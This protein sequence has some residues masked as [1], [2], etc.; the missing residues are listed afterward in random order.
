MAK[1]LQLV[2]D[3]VANR[4][5]VESGVLS[6]GRHPDNNVQIED[7][8]VSGHH[9][10]IRV[11]PNPDFPDY[12]EYFLEDLG[13]TNGSFVNDAKV[14]AAVQLHHGDIIRIAY[15]L[16]RFDLEASPS[17]AKTMHILK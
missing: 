1:L 11:C 13:S 6:I 10:R 2:D 3:V 9:A 14:Q 15:N 7:G 5:E 4:F 12:T 8:S 16:F 17:L